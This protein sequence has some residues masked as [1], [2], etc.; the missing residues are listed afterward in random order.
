[1]PTRLPRSVIPTSSSY[2]GS[3]SLL[4]LL[5]V[6]SSASRPPPQ[7]TTSAPLFVPHALLSMSARSAS[8]LTLCVTAV[9]HTRTCIWVKR[10]NMCCTAAGGSPT[11]RRARTCSRALRR[12]SLRSCPSKR[13]SGCASYSRSGQLVCGTTASKLIYHHH[14]AILLSSSLLIA[15]SLCFL[16]FLRLVTSLHS[17]RLRPSPSRSFLHS[18]QYHTL[19]GFGLKQMSRL[20]GRP[21]PAPASTVSQGRCRPPSSIF[22]YTQSMSQLV[23]IAASPAAEGQATTVEEKSHSCTVS[24]HHRPLTLTLNPNPTLNPTP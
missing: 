22:G 10:L 4:G 6:A 11:P 17:S 19:R 18:S 14:S 2:C 13:S 24:I 3:T 20:S 5:I 15:V 16:S 9:P 1:M 23:F 21:P 12:S 7:P 8:R